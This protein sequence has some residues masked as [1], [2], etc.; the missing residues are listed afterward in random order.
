M[1]VISE[2]ILAS[3]LFLALIYLEVKFLYAKATVAK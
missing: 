3:A 1:L 2:I